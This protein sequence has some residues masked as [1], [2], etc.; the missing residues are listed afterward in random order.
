[1]DSAWLDSLSED[2]VSQPRS[3]SPAGSLPSLPDD[4]HAGASDSSLERKPSSRIPL[5]TARRQSGSSKLENSV[6]PLS[7][8]S[9]NDINVPIPQHGLKQP[10]KL[11]NE[12]STSARGHRPS[13]TLSAST[14]GSVQHNT[15][16]RKSMS[17]SL[18]RPK[19]N[20]ETPEWKRRLIYGDVGYGEQRD[21]FSPAGL[22]NIFKP[23]PTQSSSPIKLP[24]LP[25]YDDTALPSSPPPYLEDPL[26]TRHPLSEQEEEDKG[27]QEDTRKGPRVVQYKLTE[28]DPDQFS[29]NDLSRGSSFLPVPSASQR[30]M[31]ARKESVSEGINDAPSET[32][33]ESELLAQGPRRLISGQ[34]DCRHNEEL[35]PIYISRHNTIDGQI[36]YAAMN[37]PANELHQ[38]LKDL[39]IEDEDESPKVLRK[40]AQSPPPMD[41]TINTEDF[42][43]NGNY[44]NMERGGR[45]AEGSFQRKMLSPS[46]LPLID[47]STMLQEESVQASTPKELPKIR[48]T[49][50]S[51]AMD[52]PTAPLTPALPP[53]PN[54]SPV[55]DETVGLKPSNGASPL[56]LFGDYDTFTNQK[57]LR[58]LSQFENVSGEERSDDGAGGNDVIEVNA[59]STREAEAKAVFLTPSSPAKLP[60]SSRASPEPCKAKRI[61]A[62]G[63]G[64][65]DE[66][67]FSEEAS[68]ETNPIEY[69]GDGQPANFRKEA[70]SSSERF[71]SQLRPSPLDDST[72]RLRRTEK[73]TTTTTEQIVT[74]V[75]TR[76]DSEDSLISATSPLI[77][78]A[79]R[80]EVL[81]TPRKRDGDSQGKRLLRSPQKDPTP[82]RR[83]TLHETDIAHAATGEGAS[84]SVQASHQSMQTVLGRKRKDARHGDEQRPANAEVMAVRQVLKPRGSSRT[85]QTH[86]SIDI[87]QNPHLDQ[88]RKIA[89]IQA[90]IDEVGP[91]KASIGIELGQPMHDESRK[92][93]VTTQDFFDEAAKIMG[94]IRDKARPR[95]DLASVEES[96]SEG[97]GDSRNG[98]LDSEQAD[99]YQ[100]STKEPFSRPPSREN[101]GPLPRLPKMQEDP[102]VLDHL[103]RFEDTVSSLEGIIPTSIKSISLARQAAQEMADIERIANE[104]VSRASAQ[105]RSMLDD[106]ESDPPNIRITEYPEVQRKRKHSTSS[107][108]IEDDQIEA[109]LGTQDSNASS[110]PSTGRSIPTGSSGGSE[111][112]HVIAP[113]TVSHLIPEFAAG[114]VFDKEK[115]SWVKKRPITE[116]TQDP[117]ALPSDSEEDPFGDIPDLTVDEAQE[118][119]RLKA[120]AAKQ[121]EARVSGALHPQNQILKHAEIDVSDE[122]ATTESS[123]S[124]NCLASDPASPS[125]PS[126]VTNLASSA[127]TPRCTRLTSWGDS[128]DSRMKMSTETTTHEHETI[129]QSNVHTSAAGEELME[130]VDQEISIYESR[131][132]PAKLRAP[133]KVTISFSSPLASFIQPEE[134]DS[135]DDAEADASH[136]Q[137]PEHVE[138]SCGRSLDRPKTRSSHG[139]TARRISL[140]GRPFVARPVSRIEERDEESVLE[141]LATQQEDR[142]VS[143]VVVTPIPQKSKS[144]ETSMVVPSAISY[145]TDAILELSPLSDFTIHQQEE[146][147]ALEVSYVAHRHHQR[148][149]ASGRR[150][151][152]LSVK[153]LVQNIT[154]VEPYEPF[155]EHMKQIELRSRSI[156]SLHMLSKFCGQLEEVDVSHNEIGQLDGAPG[157]IRHLRITNNSLTDLTSWSFL[158]NLQYLDVSNNEITSLD[159]FKDLVHLRSLRAD[160]NKIQSINGIMGLDGLISLRLRGNLLQ[161]VDFHESALQRL[162]DLDLKGNQIQEVFN[163]QELQSLAV[164]N[165]EDNQLQHF[166]VHPEETLWAL[167]YL[168]LSNNKLEQIDVSS[169]SNLRLLYLDRNRLGQIRGLLKAK[170]LDSLSL[171]EQDDGSTLD[172]SFLNEA[173][174]VRK[175]FL[176]GNLLTTFTPQV[177]FPN[178]QYLELANC[179][180]EGLP[181]AFGQLMSNV[182]VLNLNFNALKDIKPLL[183]IGRLKKLHIAGNRLTRLRKTTNILAQFPCLIKV[184]LRHNPLTLG[185]YPPV[186]EKGLVSRSC[187]DHDVTPP[188]VE[189]FTLEDGDAE[190]DQAY[191]AR[192][193]ME[194]KMRRRV[195]G[196]LMLGSSARLRLLDGLAA[197]RD[198]LGVRDQVWRELLGA[199]V[200]VDDA[201]AADQDGTREPEPPLLLHTIDEE[202]EATEH[203][204]Q[205]AD[206]VARVAA[207]EIEATTISSWGVEDSFA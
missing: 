187:S 24:A 104:T 61:N 14:T 78:V 31:H 102:E 147:F 79:K 71:R 72:T 39:T 68:V 201:V 21:L 185:F 136:H 70:S 15:M 67:E 77:H 13:R 142:N 7:E 88:Q 110:A 200:L 25:R 116:E 188:V 1:M 106:Y 44:V 84:D 90:E 178:L 17:K 64:Q 9:L 141:S 202:V 137:C 191:A 18:H 169:Y 189:P 10:S 74:H 148:R 171:R 65:L 33:A 23:P 30:A 66:F 32:S 108:P 150:S 184:D 114:M 122:Y 152:S 50:V 56:K 172:M 87:D 89:R 135:Y 46:S 112:R 119:E 57:L 45:S 60:R 2:W 115:G 167:K 183:C 131:R 123:A 162:T 170:H 54:P 62:F 164:L 8:R 101:G 149:T 58:R 207:E 165:L 181:W 182:R 92:P 85:A 59:E 52:S 118:M 193:D 128:L 204:A 155:W 93:S 105:G 156:R 86:I 16:N 29:E 134:F 121:E 146:D 203:A 38:R 91:F 34:S 20:Q 55:K 173:S 95:A 133:R 76:Q 41:A 42:A 175:L 124:G 27:N 120:V 125:E 22:E 96:D 47:E 139:T 186:T 99:S 26:E 180:L 161:Q 103:R 205:L 113:H 49:R 163:L 51:D 100:E 36:G 157:S 63:E 11:R 28:T 48:K 159:G 129:H 82:K 132:D 145:H 190:R 197:R 107:A 111:S 37:L 194:T 69:A 94:Y 196:M 130:E 174:E 143:L 3:A 81:E 75:M 127:D 195:Y 138:Q 35:S 199:G 12:I 40:S 43:H 83:R 97:L 206:S 176:S 154:D 80:V 192:L 160:N 73:V 158:R 117:N 151:L 168:K 5:R 166:F 144:H 198:I 19:H 179:G 153:Q 4:S 53:V 126:N 177:D 140:G 109:R 6:L 98:A